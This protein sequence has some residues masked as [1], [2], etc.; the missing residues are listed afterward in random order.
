MSR[1]T[2]YIPM[3]EIFRRQGCAKLFAVRRTKAKL[4]Y[5]SKG[6]GAGFPTPTFLIYNDYPRLHWRFHIPIHNQPV[7]C[8]QFLLLGIRFFM[9]Y[10]RQYVLVSF[11]DFLSMLAKCSHLRSEG[12]SDLLKHCHWRRKDI[13]LKLQITGR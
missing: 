9:V 2:P 6:R 5:Q 12:R 13:I 4:K 3:E 11:Y 7:H 8:F 1:A 10:R